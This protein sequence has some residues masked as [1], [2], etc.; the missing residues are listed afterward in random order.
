MALDPYLS[1]EPNRY[2]IDEPGSGSRVM[3]AL[4]GPLF[5]IALITAARWDRWIDE[6]EV[7]ALVDVAT[8]PEVED[9]DEA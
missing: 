7:G 3:W 9:A 4:V 8:G 2:V 5:G 6:D 1:R